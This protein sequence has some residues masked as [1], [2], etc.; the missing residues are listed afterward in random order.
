[1]RFVMSAAL[2]TVIAL[3]LIA[4][5][6]DVKG[7]MDV[8]DFGTA[9]GS[10]GDEQKAIDWF[11]RT[12]GDPR[13]NNDQPA[14][15]VEPMI[16]SALSSNDLPGDKVTT[17]P[18]DGGSIYFFVI[19]DNF[20]KDDPIAITWTYLE[21][22]KVVLSGQK[23]AGGDFGRLILEFP[24]PKS[25]WGKGKQ[26][27]TV[28]GDGATATVDFTIGDS[29]ETTPLPYN[30]AGG[31]DTSTAESEHIN[32][33]DSVYLAKN[34][35]GTAIS[36]SSGQVGPVVDS[37]ACPSGQISCNQICVNPKTDPKN[38]GTCGTV[39]PV[40]RTNSHA[41]C[42]D[43]T[44]SFACDTG[45]HIGRNGPHDRTECFPPTTEVTTAALDPC[46]NVPTNLIRNFKNCDGKCV[47]IN[48]DSDNCGGCGTRCPWGSTCKAPHVC[49]SFLGVCGPV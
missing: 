45:Y 2:T 46:A 23:A 20:K 10:S 24:K 19:Y 1:M 33:T 43:G 35:E 25:G 37:P 9:F 18:A 26:Q 30:P 13:T 44:C 38:C 48:L 12:Y 28:S 49:C 14:R 47:N 7:K 29:L 40:T 31:Q 17:F 16:T 3:L 21:N 5:C 8:S 4:G 27:I 32:S 41:L 36:G 11:I 6:A 34:P 42:N 39:C 22:G 15:F